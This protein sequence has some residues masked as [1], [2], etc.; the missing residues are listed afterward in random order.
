MLYP[1]RN[2]WPLRLFGVIVLLS[3]AA[4]LFAW[5]IAGVEDSAVVAAVPAA[6]ALLLLKL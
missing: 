1:S 4:A 3:S 6:G 2:E 5:P